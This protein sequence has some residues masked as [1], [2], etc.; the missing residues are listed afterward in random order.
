MVFSGEEK[1]VL[2]EAVGTLLWKLEDRPWQL[3]VPKELE[4]VRNLMKKLEDDREKRL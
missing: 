1:D 2:L 4:L 3:Q